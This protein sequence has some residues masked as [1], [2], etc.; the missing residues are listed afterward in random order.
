[1]EVVETKKQFRLPCQKPVKC[2][3]NVKVTNLFFIL[4]FILYF[5]LTK[6]M[7]VVINIIHI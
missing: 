5:L 7:M 3:C 1:M 6:V 4:L 2:P